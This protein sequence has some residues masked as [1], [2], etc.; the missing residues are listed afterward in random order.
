[1]KYSRIY[2]VG[3]EGSGKSTLAKKLSKKIGIKHYDLDDIVWSRRYDKKR[4]HKMRLKKL[5]ELVKKKSWIIEGAFGG[6]VEPIFK[7]TDLVIMLN[8]KYSI[9]AR[10]HVKRSLLGRFQGYEKEKRKSVRGTLKMIKHVKQYASRDH[11]KSS[12]QHRVLAEKHD[13]KLIEVRDRKDIQKL[14]NEIH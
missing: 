11:P 2:V 12:K 10:R 9:L 5:K 3:P 1:M 8:L 7:E 4:S 6:W 13:C 14:L